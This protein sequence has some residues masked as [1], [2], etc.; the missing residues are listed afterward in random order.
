MMCN[1]NLVWYRQWKYGG[2][3]TTCTARVQYK[4]T[5][6]AFPIIHGLNNSIAI[7]CYSQC[8]LFNCQAIVSYCKLD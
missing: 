7:V 2:S 5:T 3:N 1:Y 8:H 4:H 6:N